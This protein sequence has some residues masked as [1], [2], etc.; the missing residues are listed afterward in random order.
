MA[1][2]RSD[3]RA[4]SPDGSPF[5]PLAVA[6]C[7][8]APAQRVPAPRLAGAA[9]A[10]PGLVHGG[11]S[12]AGPVRPHNEDSWRALPEAGLFVVADG[13]GGY[14]AG[15]VAAEIAV[16]T[17]CRLV[18]D[19][20]MSGE[21]GVALARAFAAS[22][23]PILDWAAANPDCLG[24]G[25]TLIACLLHDGVLHVAHVGDSRA[26]LLRAGR[27]HRLTR[28]HSIGQALS[29]SG[30]VTES[31]LRNL[32]GRG[33]LTRALGVEESVACDVVAYDWEPEDRLLLCSDGVSDPLPDEAIARLLVEFDSAGAAAQAEA[34]VAAA[35]NAG[36]CDNITA[37]VVR[38]AVPGRSSYAGASGAMH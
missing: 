30:A 19:Y 37:L 7:G 21:P 26:Y 4:G 25:T 38:A 31:Q 3:G 32:P 8:L 1:S 18:P 20:S 22:N 23:H 36:G 2:I 16:D 27:L 6:R 5:E 17:A 24:M 34:L 29:D 13:M 11:C 10:V 33:I 35:V 14:R 15:E 9:A 28:D 12:D